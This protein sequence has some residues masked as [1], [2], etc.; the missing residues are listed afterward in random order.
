MDLKT[1]T[2]PLDFLFTMTN[3]EMVKKEKKWCK[4][5]KI[6]PEDE[7]NLTANGAGCHSYINENDFTHPV[8]PK[9]TY[10]DKRFYY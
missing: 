5:Q 2:P 7:Q 9:D 10:H 4:N 3:W 1:Y 6:F 8:S